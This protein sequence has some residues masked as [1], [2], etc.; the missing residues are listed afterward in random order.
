MPTRPSE[1]PTTIERSI[2]QKIRTGK[3]VRFDEPG[4]KPA[5]V[6]VLKKGWAEEVQG[7][8][9]VAYRITP[10]GEDAMKARIP[11]RR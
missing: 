7:S 6:R 3:E 8:A 10:A 4:S 2:L 9:S 11:L 5:L 1:F